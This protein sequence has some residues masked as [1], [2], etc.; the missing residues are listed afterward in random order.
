MFYTTFSIFF[1]LLLVKFELGDGRWEN[2]R[3][4]ELENRR[5]GVPIAKGRK[6]GEKRGENGDGR[7]EVFSDSSG[8]NSLDLM[9]S[10]HLM[11]FELI[12]YIDN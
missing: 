9:K 5:I 3:I 6:I 4:G 1:V 7:T 2:R 11:D 12:L 10:F 8:F